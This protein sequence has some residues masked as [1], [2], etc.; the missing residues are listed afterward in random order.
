VGS[1][2]GPGRRLSKMDLGWKGLVGD[3]AEHA[4]TAA[5]VGGGILGVEGF[6]KLAD[7]EP[8]SARRTAYLGAFGEKVEL[9]DD[10]ATLVFIFPIQ[11]PETSPGSANDPK[12]RRGAG[13]Q[14]VTGS[15]SDSSESSDAG[16]AG[17]AWCGGGKAKGETVEDPCEVAQEIFKKEGRDD[18]ELSFEGEPME[19]YAFFV[20]LRAHVRKV[21]EGMNLKVSEFNSIDDDEVFMKVTADELVLNRLGVLFMYDLP[22]M[23]QAYENHGHEVP[24]DKDGQKVF[25]HHQ[26]TRIFGKFLQ[27]FRGVDVIRLLLHYVRMHVDLG[28]LEEQGVK[29]FPSANYEEAKTL[30]EQWARVVQPGPGGPKGPLWLF[31]FLY[32]QLPQYDMIEKV[33]DYFGEEI[34]Y[35]FSFFAVYIRVLALLALA[36][37]IEIPLEACNLVSYDMQNNVKL[38]FGFCVVVWATSFQLKLGHHDERSKQR[39]GMNNRKADE[40]VLSDYDDA[41]DDSWQVRLYT[42]GGNVL[43]VLYVFLFF[44]TWSVVVQKIDDRASKTKASTAITF[45]FAWLWGAKFAPLLVTGQNHRT[46]RRKN[47]ALVQTL[48]YVKLAV[49]LIP[50]IYPAFLQ[51]IF[52]AQCYH[53][54]EAA[55]VCTFDTSRTQDAYL[56]SGSADFCG[57]ELANRNYSIPQ[58]KNFDGSGDVAQDGVF[59][60][61]DYKEWFKEYTFTVGEDHPYLHWVKTKHLGLL[62][63]LL[64]GLKI[65]ESDEVCVWGCVPTTCDVHEGDGAYCLTECYGL[66]RDQLLQVFAVHVACTIAFLGIPLFITNQTAKRGWLWTRR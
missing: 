53:S 47:H 28:K 23:E 61:P 10:G 58:V 16:E 25:A 20:K 35:F 11:P 31:R 3:V 50:F 64:P 33:R 40:S 60:M 59:P 39:W 38:L 42:T 37:C 62:R 63:T 8:G 32:R 30:A 46:Q 4:K 13:W 29:W 2:P 1:R 56:T 19:K 44:T 18:V 66:L 52:S 57:G 21:F 24:R 6:S 9:D 34:A 17:T 7:E 15:E 65:Q 55:Y 14:K 54:L 26:F 36:A 51:D 45:A 12:R 48:A 49:F 22:F 27:D 41:K 5:S 43:M